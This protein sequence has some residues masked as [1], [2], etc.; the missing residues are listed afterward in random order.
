VTAALETFGRLEKYSTSRVLILHLDGPPNRV[1]PVLDR[2]RTGKLIDFVTPVLVDRESG[3]RQVLTDEIVVRLKSG[4]HA[5]QTLKSLKQE[6]GLEV[7]RQN[8][9]EPTQ[10]IVKVPDSSGT[11]TM[12]M[13]QS[14]DRR[15]DV[16][17]ASPNFLTAIKR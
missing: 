4:A 8:E 15:Q 9:F 3:L 6:H 13:A 14:L 10:Y 5:K 2:L 17:F 16:E 11:E 12:K 7:A 1:Q